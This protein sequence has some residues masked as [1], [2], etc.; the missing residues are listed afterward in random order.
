[1]STAPSTL[2]WPHARVLVTGGAGFLGSAIRRVL[3]A[4][5]VP[6]GHVF[7]PRSR[8]FDLTSQEGARRLFDAASAHWQTHGLPTDGGADVIIHAAA[9]VGGIVANRDRPADFFRDNTLMA[10]NLVDE[11]LRRGIAEQP[12]KGGK[13]VGVGSMT[14]YPADAP[15]PY[16]EDALWTGYPP[17][18][19]VPYGVAKLALWQMLDACRSQHGLR[20][21]YVVPV[22][23]YG[24]GDNIENIAH[25]H[26]A[27]S[28]VKRFVDAVRE[29]AE[30]VTCWGTGSPTREF[31]YIDDAAEGIVRAAEVMDE[32]TPINLGAGSRGEIAIRGL[33]ALIGQLAGY[34]GR[35]EWD[36]TKPDGQA[37]RVLDVSR[38]EWLLGWHADTPLEEGLTKTIEWY[39]GMTGPCVNRPA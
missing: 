4:R 33:A 19:S 34:E 32:P 26:V 9:T 21:A 2:H 39:R 30:T 29:G 17:Q 27:G 20:A 22:N 14:S 18:P 28:L 15:L 24:P 31:L 8:E 10:I 1:M 38:A 3:G 16:H 7:V 37:R 23:L 13:I 25:A 36:I 35:I 6:E 5:G 12:G 11:A